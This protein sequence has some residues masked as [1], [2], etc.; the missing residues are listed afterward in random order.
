MLW[1][2]WRAILFDFWRLLILSAAVL[3]T[4]VAFAATVKP[5]AD[6]KLTADQAIRFMRYAIPP[7]LAYTLPFAGGF[8][9][10]LAYHR[11]VVENEVTAAHAGGIGHRK[12][13]LPALASGMLLAGGLMYLN[14]RVIPNYLLSMERMITRDFARL[15]VNSLRQGEAARIGN[16]E[17]HADLVE[18]RRPEPGSPAREQFLLAGVG[19]VESDGEG[20]VNIDGTARRAWI[21]LMPTWALGDEDRARIGDEADTAVIV[22]FI[23]VTVYRAGAPQTA[24]QLVL[25]AIPIASVFRDNPKFYSGARL[26]EIAVNPDLMSNV[27]RQRAGLARTLGASRA[28]AGF[29]EDLRRARPIVLNAPDGSGVRVLGMRLRS[30]GRWWVIDPLDESGLVEVEVRGPDGRSDRLTARTARLGLQ[31]AAENDPLADRSAAGSSRFVLELAGVRL[32]GAGTEIAQTAYRD[33]WP[34]EDPTADLLGLS[35]PELIEIARADPAAQ[36]HGSGVPQAIRE[37]ERVI[38]YVQGKILAKQH[39]RWALSASCVVMVVLGA[40]MAMHLKQTTPLV[41]YLWSFFPAL[42]SLIVL[43]S[44]QQMI[45]NRGGI[46]VFVLWSGVVSLA[47]L[48]VVVYRRMARL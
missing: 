1:T 29:A 14:D 9:A 24:E 7:M 2:L 15:M 18:E 10:T 37:V 33:L 12:I 38:D 11:F 8:A 25:P 19:M 35:S 3:V 36:S 6:G 34:A 27:D 41:I 22:K 31:T 23:D 13:L 16:T 40:V 30:E 46:G 4:V 32:L 39:E 45:N 43:Q 28:Y 21:L 44:G 5:L 17:I 48:T 26:R 42:A 47:I 20:R